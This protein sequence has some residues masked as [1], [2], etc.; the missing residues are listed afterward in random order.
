MKERRNTPE[1]Y[2]SILHAVDIM[3]EKEYRSGAHKIHGLTRIQQSTGMSYNQF[4]KFT[5]TLI[6]NKLL[7]IN[8]LSVT[9]KGYQFLREFE[10]LNKS[11]LRLEKIICEINTVTCQDLARDPVNIEHKLIDTQQVINAQNAIIEELE[12]K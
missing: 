8:P 3:I 10:I 7:T 11:K 6:T 12:D 5:N 1:L 9:L 4:L 2:Q